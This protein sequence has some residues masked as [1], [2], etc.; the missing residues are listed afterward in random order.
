MSWYRVV[1]EKLEQAAIFEKVSIV[2]AK[3]RASI[4]ETTFLDIHYD[5]VTGS[6]SYALIERGGEIGEWCIA[7]GGWTM[8]IEERRVVCRS[9]SMLAR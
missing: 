6:Y 5:P 9:N 8:K 4:D 2:G 7:Y 1:V 3:V